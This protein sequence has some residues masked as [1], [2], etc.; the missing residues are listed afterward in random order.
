[1]NSW[2]QGKLFVEHTINL[3]HDTLH[4]LVG[5]LLWL[6][7]ALL[8][9]RPISAW[10]PWLWLFAVIAWNET[11]D[12][13]LEHWPDAGQQYGEGMKDLLLTMFVPTILL[14]A[15]RSRPDLFRSNPGAAARRRRL[16]QRRG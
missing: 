8:L 15:A 4:V 6:V 5:V 13:W 14:I 1:M 7:I 2:H 16:R 12:L 9:R 11:V 10:L 3:S